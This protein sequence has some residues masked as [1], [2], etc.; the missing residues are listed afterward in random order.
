MVRFEHEYL[1]DDVDYPKE[2]LRPTGWRMDG[3]RKKW[4]RS[5]TP[6]EAARL[7]AICR[8]YGVAYTIDGKAPDAPKPAMSL[9]RWAGLRRATITV[10]SQKRMGGF[11]TVY[12]CAYIANGIVAWGPNRRNPIDA[13]EAAKA[14]DESR[15]A[16]RGK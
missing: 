5:I 4:S 2:I 9:R 15:R 7:A 3:V 6:A 12:A 16:K 13:M 10:D 14:Q 11:R 1:R 8:K